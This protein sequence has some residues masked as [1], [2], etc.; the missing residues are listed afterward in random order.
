MAG[1]LLA[2]RVLLGEVYPSPS[3]AEPLPA[4]TAPSPRQLIG[5]ERLETRLGKSAPT[6]KGIVIGHVEGGK[7]DYLPN[8][9]AERYRGVTFVT[10]SGPGKSNGHADATTMIVVGAGGLAPGVDQVICFASMHWMTSGF[11]HGGTDQPPASGPV[12][13]FTHSWIGDAANGTNEVLRRLDYVIDH[14]DVIAVVGIN[15]GAQ[16]AVPALLAS[17]YNVISVGNDEGISSGGYTR[18]EGAGRCKPELVAPMGLTSFATPVVAACAARLLEAADAKGLHSPARH[19]AL[20]KALLLAG[21]EKPKGWRPEPGKPLD[22]HLGA[23]RVRIDQSYDILA[24]GAVSPGPVRNRCAWAYESLPRNAKHEYDFTLARPMGEASL[25]LVWNRRIDGRRL[26][27]LLSGEPRWVDAP[28]LA[29]F[30]LKLLRL[31]E[32]GQESPLASSANMI[33]NLEHIY[34]PQMAAG[35][36]RIEITRKDEFAD[37]WDYALAW[38]VENAP[39]PAEQA[40]APTPSP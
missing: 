31:D 25:V 15:N 17:A 29:D 12:R 27:D 9:N 33:D 19:A 21:A 24:A 39:S 30:D 34:L 4:N 5:L 38:R 16:S 2:L 10:A 11:L 26:H 7:G 37:A 40:A 32:S 22:S 8:L 1:A 23:G 13:I 35:R 20:I 14:D 6:G 36:Y 3:Q 28:R 18:H